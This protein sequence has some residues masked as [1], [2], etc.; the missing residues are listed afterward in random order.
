MPYKLVYVKFSQVPPNTYF[1]YKGNDTWLKG[2][3]LEIID[4]QHNAY[5]TDRGTMKPQTATFWRFFD[6]NNIVQV[7]VL[8]V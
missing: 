5:R 4:A 8:E 2:E 3:C 7:R 6:H 1:T